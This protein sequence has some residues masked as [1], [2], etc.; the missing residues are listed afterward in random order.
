MGTL[1]F[2]LQLYTVRDHLDK[3]VPGTLAKVKAMG[4]DWV[5][6]AGTHGLTHEAFLKHLEQAGLRMCSM[7]VGYDDVTK[8]VPKVVG[9]ARLYNVK[10]VVIS[11]IDRRL[12][13][14][15]EGWI[16]C[17]K[18]LDAA[19][20][21]LGRSGIQLCYHNHAHEFER[22]GNEYAYDLLFGAARREN[23]AAQIDTFWVRYAGLDPV[24]VINR[25]SGRCPLLHVK[26][27]SDADS[28]AFAEMGSGILPWREIFAAAAQAGTEW[29]IVEQDTCPG[30]SL[31]SAETSAKFMIRQ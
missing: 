16:A 5:E 14:D 23:L 15:R 26:D 20:A 12:T 24:T 13:P 17:G 1:K 9:W 19:G 3:D 6:G 10:Y 18:A 2:A 4:Y 22:F 30:D 11:G 27:M 31:E 29:Y 25:Y 7:H 21:A 28:R 8:D